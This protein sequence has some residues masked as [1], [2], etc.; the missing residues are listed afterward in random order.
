MKINFE[1]TSLTPISF[2]LALPD[3]QTYKQDTDH[4]LTLEKYQEFRLA[5]TNIHDVVNILEQQELEARL[6]QFISDLQYVVVTGKRLSIEIGIKYKKNKLIHVVLFCETLSRLLNTTYPQGV[7]RG[8]E[9]YNCHNCDKEIEF[10]GELCP[11]CN[12]PAP[13]C[14]LCFNDP[15]ETDKVVKFDCCQSYAHLDHAISWL[16]KSDA[17]PYCTTKDPHY[18]HVKELD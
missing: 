3:F 9:R 16:E 6:N 11:H 2:E 15:D 1:G 13:R 17:C 14:V 10:H 8:F 5:S 7:F 18:V 4:Q 12:E